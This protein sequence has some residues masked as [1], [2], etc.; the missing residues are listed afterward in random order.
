MTNYDKPARRELVVRLTRLPDID[1]PRAAAE[2]GLMRYGRFALTRG[3][4]FWFAYERSSHPSNTA[5]G[6]YWAIA[7]DGA[8]LVSARGS[9]LDGQ[10]LFGAQ[11][12]A[13]AALIAR[14][15]REG[16]I[17]KPTSIRKEER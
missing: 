13:L 1:S 8:L 12:P 14:L 3:G 6:W 5:I 11:A 17:P 16:I 4:S 2:H 15:V 7:P 10:E 9:A